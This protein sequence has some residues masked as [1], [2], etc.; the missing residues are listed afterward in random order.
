MA[1]NEYNRGRFKESLA[2]ADKALAAADAKSGSDHVLGYRSGTL[3]IKAHAYDALGRRKDAIPC[4]EEAIDIDERRTDAEEGQVAVSC[5]S[6]AIVLVQMDQPEKAVAYCERANLSSLR[7]TPLTAKL[8]NMAAV[9]YGSSDVMNFDKAKALLLKAKKISERSKENPPHQLLASIRWLGHMHATGDNDR[10]KA[11]ELYDSAWRIV[12]KHGQDNFDQEELYHLVSFASAT[13]ENL[14]IDEP[15]TEERLESHFKW[16]SR[17]IRPVAALLDSGAADATMACAYL[18]A[19]ISDF[20]SQFAMDKTATIE[21]AQVLH[22]ILTDARRE[23]LT[24]A[25]AEWLLGYLH[26]HTPNWPN[27]NMDLTSMRAFKHLRNAIKTFDS[28]G[29]TKTVIYGV[30]RGLI[31]EV[32]LANG[33]F[34]R[35][36][37]DFKVAMDILSGHDVQNSAEA[38]RYAK[39]YSQATKGRDI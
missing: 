5:V 31:G 8:L 16:L 38:L 3:E 36:A 2:A 19:V 9:V 24:C 23:L 10:N 29:K 13:I 20:E 26:S 22:K 12:E 37:A 1:V 39:L 4:L 35:A 11:L 27:S 33:E 17:V 25:N 18:T 30:G 32:R 28:L 34:T 6:L 15:I 14:L 7:P 21:R